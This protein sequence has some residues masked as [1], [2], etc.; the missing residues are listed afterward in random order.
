MNLE[1]EGKAALVAASS[2]GMGRAIAQGLAAEGARVAICAREEKALQEAAEA[3]RTST[4]GQVLAMPADVT[5]PED[6]GKLVSQTVAAFGTVHILVNN[7]G[8]PPPGLFDEL[9]DDHWQGAFAL[10]LLSTIRLTREVL[11]YMRQQRWGR[12]INL[13]SISVKQPIEG[14]ILSNAI[15]TGV[16][17]LAKTLS[18][19]LGRDNITVNNVCPGRI[20][21]ERLRSVTA[22]RAT[23]EGK[24]LEEALQ[25]GLRDIPLHR[26]GQP[27][28]LANLVVFLASERASYITGTTIQVDG[29]LVRG[30]L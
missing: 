21:T 29:G 11:P 19:E 12:I 22:Q 25:A 5:R 17:G 1:L 20:L 8:G 23:R 26:Y 18:W 30:L 27:E 16:I 14:L 10:N 7:A 2:K 15:R 9:T 6:L 3:I 28:E 4:G 24:T 13:T